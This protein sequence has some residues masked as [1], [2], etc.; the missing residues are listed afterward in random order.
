MAK[1]NLSHLSEVLDKEI[2]SVFHVGIDV[3]KRSYHLAFYGCNGFLKTFV[4]PADPKFVVGK[5]IAHRSSIEQVAYEAG[6]TGFELARQLKEAGLPVLVIAPSRVP[7]PVTQGAKTDRLDCIKLSQY[8]AAGM[9]KGIAIPSRTDEARR[10]LIRR[11]HD[12]ADAIRRTKQRIRSHLLYLGVT[13]PEG[14]EN[15]NEKAVKGLS[16]LVLQQSAKD[17]LDSL[18][19]EL[20]FLK[21]EQQHVEKQIRSLCREAERAKAFACLQ[22]APGVGPVTAST[23]LLELFEPQRFKSG[24]QLASYLGLAPMVRQSGESKGKAKLRPVGQKRL[25]SLLVEA[26]WC[27]CRR[28]QKAGAKYNRIVSKSNIKQKAI[29]AVAKDLAIILWRL[30]VEQRAYQ[31]RAVAA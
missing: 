22:T 23:F 3:H 24:E 30:L 25:R 16:K 19:R 15:W 2:G 8:S 11:R 7:R 26:A 13:E 6:P 9:L 27:W 12:L 29:V 14:L 31:V 4:G 10:S 18:V 20:T 28:D 5:L 1:K 17:T 21:K